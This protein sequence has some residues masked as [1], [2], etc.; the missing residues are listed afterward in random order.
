MY[1]YNSIIVIRIN[2]SHFPRFVFDFLPIDSISFPF[3]GDTEIRLSFV[4][5]DLFGPDLLSIFRSKAVTSV[6][7]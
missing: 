3:H 1:N 5:I 7:V 2:Y 6:I 4:P